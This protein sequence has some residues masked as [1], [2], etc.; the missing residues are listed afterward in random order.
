MDTFYKSLDVYINTSIHEGIP[1]SL[2]E[3]MSHGLPVVVTKVGGFPEIVD[4][5]VNSYLIDSRDLSVFAV[6]CD[7]LL[8]DPEKR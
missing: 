2:L 8:S 5:G 1:M 7:E 4:Q 6:R 3:A